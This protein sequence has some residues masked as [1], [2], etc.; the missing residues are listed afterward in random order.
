MERY[1]PVIIM[2]VVLLMGYFVFRPLVRR[3]FLGKGSAE[4]GG[5]RLQMLRDTSLEAAALTSLMLNFPSRIMGASSISI[6]LALTLGLL[7]LPKIVAPILAF[8]VVVV[9]LTR[10]ESPLAMKLILVLAVFVVLRFLLGGLLG[11][12]RK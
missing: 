9:S 2:V 5:D 4:A 3:F 7:L 1:S 10:L 12:G 8:F 11:L 6:L